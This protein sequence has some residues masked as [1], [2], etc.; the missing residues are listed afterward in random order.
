M[1]QDRIPSTP[2]GS[3]RKFLEQLSGAGKAIGVLT[4]GGDAQG[5]RP[6]SQAGAK[7]STDQKGWGNQGIFKEWGPGASDAGTGPERRVWEQ[8]GPLEPQ[9]YLPGSKLAIQLA[10]VTAG[11]G[12]AGVC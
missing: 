7:G 3:F 12:E 5:A 9:G 4:S 6:P 2:R 1:D 11:A 10:R 8:P